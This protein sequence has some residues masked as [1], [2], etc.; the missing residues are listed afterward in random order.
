MVD[1]NSVEIE[2]RKK[3]EKVYGGGHSIKMGGDWKNLKKISAQL[4][5]DN[6]EVLRRMKKPF[7]FEGEI[8]DA[9]DMP[10]IV[11]ELVD[12]TLKQKKVKSDKNKPKVKEYSKEDLL[13]MDFSKLK[14]IA[15]KFGETGRSKKGLI[16]D[17]LKAQE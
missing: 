1:M 3:H 11:K 7:S 15:K 13:K 2:I 6:P 16:E 14:K 17:I 12:T 5:L 9:P 8:L 4:I 10:D